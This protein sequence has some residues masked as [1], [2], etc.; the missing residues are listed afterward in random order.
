MTGARKN[1]A[2]YLTRP[3]VRVLSRTPVTPNALT[4]F[5]LL[6]TVG[7]AIIIVTGHLF[8]AGFVVLIAGFLDILDGALA[9]NTGRTTQF[10]AALDSTFDRLA[11]AALMLSIL[12]LYAREQSVTEV[13]IVGL[14]LVGS[15]LVSYI[16][17]KAEA[18]GLECRVGIFTRAE[19]VIIIALGLFLSQIEYAL[20]IAMA[21][22]MVLSFITVAQRIFHV[23]RQ[24]RD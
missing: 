1:I 7:A 13:L 21:I 9:R 24:T 17:A 22:I 20:I 5:G 2:D 3:A 10:G 8:A 23:W 11:D 12:V 19:R 14:A 15:L 6:V 4:C 16:R 18:M